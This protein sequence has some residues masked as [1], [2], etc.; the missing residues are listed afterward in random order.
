[1]RLRILFGTMILVL[2]LG[3]YALGV[4]ALAALIPD[5]WAVEALFYATAGIL[6]IF[7]AAKL[8]RWMQQVGSFRPPLLE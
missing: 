4:V 7:P 6:W 2:G 5:Q 1:M 3:F 8:T